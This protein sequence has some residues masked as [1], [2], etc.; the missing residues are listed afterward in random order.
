LED[1]VDISKLANGKRISRRTTLILLGMTGTLAACA[2]SGILA[3]S[4]PE[5]SKA[6]IPTASVAG[7]EPSVN[8]GSKQNKKNEQVYIIIHG[9]INETSAYNIYDIASKVVISGISHINIVISSSG[10]NTR[11]ALAIYNFL[12][13]LPVA[14]TTYNIA[15]ID[16][17]ANIIFLAGDKRIASP[18]ARFMMH[19][20]TSGLTGDG[21]MNVFKWKLEGI[22]FDQNA[23]ETIYRNRTSMDSNTIEKIRTDTIYFDA[24]EARKFGIVN[25]VTEFRM[26]QNAKIFPIIPVTS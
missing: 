15:N 7:G 16:S 4:H 9:L 14:I 10:G 24:Y 17:C 13:G 8:K 3:G 18:N 1:G 2:P 23:F 6:L 20:I 12:R 21:T 19:P 11:E 26:P 22:A 25:S 5:D